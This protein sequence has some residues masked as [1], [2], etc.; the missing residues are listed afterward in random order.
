MNMSNTNDAVQYIALLSRHL[1]KYDTWSVITLILLDLDFAINHDGTKYLRKAILLYMQY[2][3]RTLMKVIYADVGRSF[4]PIVKAKQVEH[5]MRYAVDEAWGRRS[6]DRWGMLFP[7][8][9]DW[10]AARPTSSQFIARIACLIKV[11]QACK[12]GEFDEQENA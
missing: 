10:Q 4:V 11:W 1:N 8:G 5:S 12:E 3:E 6:G 2:P 9:K 7:A